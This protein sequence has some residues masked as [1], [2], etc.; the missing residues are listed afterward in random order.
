M[1]ERRT[2]GPNLALTPPMGWNSFNTFGCEP[3]EALIKESADALVSTGLRDAGYEYLNIDDGWMAKERDA[4]G[5]LVVDPSKFPN[6]LACVADYAHE[7]G[8]KIGV[9][10]GAAIRT[11]GENMGSYGHARQDAFC[12]AGLGFDFLKY[13]YRD[14]PEDPP[15]RDVKREYEEMRDYLIEADRPMVF[16]LCEHG[17]SRPWEWAYQVGHLWRS[18]P[19]IKD[20][21]DGDIKWGMGFNKIVDLNER[22]YPFAGPGY[23]NDPDMLVVGMKGR[24]E[25]QGSGCTNAEYRSHFALWCLMAAPLFIG[26]DIRNMDDA[27]REILLNKSLIAVNQDPLGIQGHVVRRDRDFDIWVKKLSGG[28]VAIGLYNRSLEKTEIAV[29]WRELGLT[30]ESQKVRDLWTD[31]YLGSVRSGFIRLVE[32]HDCLVFRVGE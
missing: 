32:P 8:L 23:W 1:M 30:S 5:C 22:L 27:T 6:G 7:R 20:G 12:I 14:L 16:S 3:T 15:G 19:D 21:Y 10:L 13:D 26:C 2:S 11:Y 9:Y 29:N 24:I 28:S 18:T 4:G 17:R 25:W 31:E